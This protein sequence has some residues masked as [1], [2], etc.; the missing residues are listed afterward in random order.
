MRVISEQ[1]SAVYTQVNGHSACTLGFWLASTAV[2]GA[3]HQDI[4]SYL[5]EHHGLIFL[6]LIL[7]KKQDYQGPTEQSLLL[8]NCPTM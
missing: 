3:F 4:G 2:T 1:A 7:G 8:K 6:L 5:K